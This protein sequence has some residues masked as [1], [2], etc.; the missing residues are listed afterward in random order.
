MGIHVFFRAATQDPAQSPEQ[1]PAAAGRGLFICR[2]SRACAAIWECNWHSLDNG[3]SRPQI[4]AVDM[5]P[6]SV[7]VRLSQYEWSDSTVVPLPS[8]CGRVLGQ[9]ALVAYV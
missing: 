2:A 5:I 6:R 8:P 1:I 9:V 7:F 4:P 3:D